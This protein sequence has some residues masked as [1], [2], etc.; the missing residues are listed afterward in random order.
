M[1]L[2][3]L[4]NF[5]IP[6]LGFVLAFG[7]VVIITPLNVRVAHKNG[8]IAQVREDRWHSTPT[9][10]MGGITIY[11]GAT[12]SFWIAGSESFPYI[13]WLGATLLFIGGLYDDLRGLGAPSKLLIQFTA[14]TLLVLSGH[15]LGDHWPLW[16]AVP[17]TYFWVIGITNAINLIDGMDGL[18][19]GITSIAFL[20]LSVLLAITGHFE[21]LLLTL[22]MAGASAGFIVYNFK[23]AK[24]FMGDCGSMFLGFTLAAAAILV[25]NTIGFSGILPVLILPA[26]VLAV[27]IFDTT[28]VTILRLLS[29]RSISQG[30]NDHTMHRLVRLGISERRTVLTLYLVSAALGLLAVLL[31]TTG[32]HILYSLLIIAF[33]GLIHF[34]IYLAGIETYEPAYEKNKK[35]RL[36]GLLDNDYRIIRFILQNKKIIAAHGADIILICTS[37]LVAYQLYFGQDMTQTHL[38]QLYY[39]IPILI[40]AKLIAFHL[41]KIYRGVWRFTGEPDIVRIIAASAGG[42]VF[43]FTAIVLLTGG[44]LFTFEVLIIYWLLATASIAGIR[45]AYRSIQEYLSRLRVDGKRVLLYGADE[46]GYL[47]LREML[48]VPRLKIIPVGFLDND[49]ERFNSSIHGYK[50]FGDCSVLANLKDKE[51]IQEVNIVTPHVSREEKQKIYEQCIE[52][53]ILCRD[54]TSEY[55][56]HQSFPGDRVL[57][58]GSGREGVQV[59]DEMQRN[60]KFSLHPAAF[61]NTDHELSQ[62]KVKRIPYFNDINELPGIIKRFEINHIII[63]LPVASGEHIRE[64]MESCNRLPVRKSILPGIFENGKSRIR[65]EELR[66]VKIEDYYRKPPVVTNIKE[67]SNKVNGKTVL[68]TG[69]GSF[70][71]QELCRQVLDFKPARLILVGG[72]ESDIETLLERLSG[73]IIYHHALFKEPT[74]GSIPEIVPVVA[75]VRSQSRL[76]E[77]FERYSPDIVVHIGN[78]SDYKVAAYNTIEYITQIVIGTRNLLYLSLRFGV[79]HFVLLSDEKAVN[80]Y[81]L[82]G[83]G[84]RIAELSVFHAAE[85]SSRPFMVTR[86]GS[87][88]GERSNEITSIMN[89]IHNNE[90]VIIPSPYAHR[91]FTFCPEVVQLILHS[92]TIYNRRRIYVLNTENTCRLEHI[93]HELADLNGRKVGRDLKVMYSGLKEHEKL[94]DEL[95]VNGAVYYRSDH[96]Y[97]YVED[98]DFEY[99]ADEFGALFE[100]L[101]SALVRENIVQIRRLMEALVPEYRANVKN[102]REREV[103]R[104][105]KNFV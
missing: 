79:N 90:T 6:I 54:F 61:I 17:L 63:A 29:G 10:L 75:D 30:G 92:L 44:T 43:A 74:Q 73:K 83:A 69:A 55:S 48:Q 62:T 99:S 38:A 19:A 84:K 24:I 11:V 50:V 53:G 5:L 87:V 64:I 82:I 23:P 31:F 28:L 93:V 96:A 89:K 26:L 100:E 47:K 72:S 68:V 104:D 59:I 66:D 81:S 8:W 13:V 105:V 12:L 52:N 1:I 57:I 51:N 88:L 80:P 60:P 21:L 27:P 7:L 70:I 76:K 86:F 67:I 37:L 98:N 41:F 42:S 65:L 103:I 25:Q 85:A 77:A 15:I 39:I 9:A 22:T 34:G 35:L 91:F 33:L 16:F 95:R 45:F 20:T 3:G 49:I 94:V 18:A 58:I 14:V 46:A 102:N 40:G 71:S 56:F 101:L 36:R 2:S 4:E 32:V 78:R 97:I